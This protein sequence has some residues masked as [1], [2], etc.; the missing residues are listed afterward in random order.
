MRIKQI[1]PIEATSAKV[2][3]TFDVLGVIEPDSI[4]QI[5]A[6]DRSG[7]LS[8][9]VAKT[10]LSMNEHFGYSEILDLQ[11]GSFYAIACCPRTVTSNVPDDTVD[12][13][14]WEGLCLWQEFTTQAAP[15]PPTDL[16]AP[17]ITGIRTLPLTLHQKNGIEV[18]WVS[19]RSYDFFQVRWGYVGM[20][21][22]D[23][24]QTKTAGGNQG[25]FIGEPT[26]QGTMYHFSVQGCNSDWLGFSHCSPWSPLTKAHAGPNLRSLRGFLQASGVPSS[27]LR[28]LMG[29]GGGKL[30]SLMG[31]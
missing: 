16:P 29:A 5:Y 14:Y 9:L 11:A 17:Q 4:V 18:S 31:V 6:A 1:P 27:P 22:V 26:T 23:E 2:Q 15:G 30:R 12:G 7:D 25:S 13:Q 21:A 3:V 19:A 20:P 10:E 28:S 8:S 24:N